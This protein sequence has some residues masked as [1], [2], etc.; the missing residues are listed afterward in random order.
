[1]KDGSLRP[2]Q[3]YRRLNARTVKNCYLLPLISE[4]V[5]KLYHA[6]IFT[7]LDIRW[8][9]NNVHIKEGDEHKAA[10]VTSWGC[11]EPLVMFF[12]LTNSLATF[13]TMMNDMFWE[14]I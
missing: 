7:K 6:S 10:F 8:G 11:F 3:D 13:Q 14:L 1:M 12:G 5:H 9:Y 4:F 2:V